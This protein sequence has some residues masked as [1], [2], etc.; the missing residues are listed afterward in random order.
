MRDPQGQFFY[1]EQTVQT[2]ERSISA[3]RLQPYLELAQGHRL[4]AIRLYEWNT[5]LSEALYSIIQGFEVCLR[6]AIHEVMTEAYKHADWYDYAPLEGDQRNQ[7]EQAKQRIIDDGR[8][9]TSGRVVAELMFGFWTALMG[10]A[11]AQTF[12]D[13]HLHKAFR[14]ARIKRKTIAKR[15]KKI[16]FLRNR[17]AHHESIIGKVGRERNLKQDVQ[18]IIEATGWICTITAKWITFNSTFDQHCEGRPV[19]PVQELPL[20]PPELR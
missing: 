1:D 5:K 2:L 3:E 12:W 13:H 17:V 4:Y 14:E 20:L 11:Y 10:T 8:E 16:R 19:Q 6:N 18:E 15:L 9:V 7:V